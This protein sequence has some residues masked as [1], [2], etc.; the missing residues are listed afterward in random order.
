MDKKTARKTKL[1]F[2]LLGVI[3]GMFLSP[4]RMEFKFDTND[5]IHGYTAVGTASARAKAGTAG[6]I[7][8]KKRGE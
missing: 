1:L 8:V 7:V 3:I 5:H 4:R 6:G 2:L